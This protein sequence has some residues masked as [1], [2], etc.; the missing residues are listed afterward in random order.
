MAECSVHCLSQL[1]AGLTEEGLKNMSVE[2]IFKINDR[3]HVMF[4]QPAVTK[5]IA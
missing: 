1:V 3:R 5:T 2:L 4:S